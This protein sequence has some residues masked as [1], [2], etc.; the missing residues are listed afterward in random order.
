MGQHPLPP[1]RH[2]PHPLTPSD[3]TVNKE[4][5]KNPEKRSNSQQIGLDCLALY[6]QNPGLREVDLEPRPKIGRDKIKRL[7]L[8]RKNTT[9]NKLH[10]TA[11][12]H[13]QEPELREVDLEPSA[14]RETNR[15][16]ALVS[17]Y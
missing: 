17:L 11:W 15:T 1:A 10:C 3:K 8:R 7:I 9:E 4:E 16:E 14:K 2:Q 5:T 12:T 13:K 6:T